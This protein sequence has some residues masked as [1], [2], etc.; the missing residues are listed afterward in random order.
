MKK[1]LR[2]ISKRLKNL[3]P[4][5]RE[6]P[7]PVDPEKMKPISKGAGKDGAHKI[8]LEIPSKTVVKVLLIIVLFLAG[9]E[10]VI[11]LKS[12]LIMAFISGLLTLG[13][14][15]LLN[16]LEARHIPRPLGIIILYV[17][18][19]GLLTV[20][21][22]RIIPIVSDQLT[23]IAKDLKNHVLTQ[24]IKIP[25]FELFQ[26]E[27][28]GLQSL[29]A[30]NLTDISKNLQKIAGSTLSVI[31][32]V[33]Q[34]VFNFLL[35]LTLLFFMLLERE[36]LGHSLIKLFPKRNRAYVAQK[37]HSIQL[38]MAEWFRGQF[39][40]MVIV[41]LW[42]YVGMTIL[43]W[44]VGMK[45]AATIAILAAFAE[46][47]PY[48]GPFL[49]Y[50]LVGLIGSN[51]SMTAFITGIAFVGLTQF[52]EG[53]MLVPVVMRKAVGLSSVVVILALAVGGTLGY[54]SGGVATAIVGM[55]FA[56][57]VAASVAMIIG[58]EQESRRAAKKSKK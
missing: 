5:E 35:T 16:K 19:L 26:W 29:L 42:V 2:S 44:T 20:L 54:A 34:G 12:L 46:L 9:M 24:G 41:G 47:L 55:I 18:F 21:F 57:P 40:L 43:G 8:E 39:I 45:Y 38:K 58:E 52:L 7:E 49:T 30:E 17:V 53:N 31:T 11:Q 51:I 15:P 36:R 37:T 32:S 4:P 14:S 13:I 28:D 56:I 10:I 25:G 27:A 1:L 23:E 50:V 22:I 33:F 3:Q 48:V 6:K